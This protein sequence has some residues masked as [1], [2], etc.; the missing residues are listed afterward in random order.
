LAATALNLQLHPVN[1]PLIFFYKNSIEKNLDIPEKDKAILSNLEDDFKEIF[2]ISTE[3]QA[4]FM[5]R[6]F[7]ASSSPERTIRKSTKKIF[8]I[9][10]A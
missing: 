3:H 2:T 9:G 5:F 6:I 10:R 8:S 1:V 7:K 4:I